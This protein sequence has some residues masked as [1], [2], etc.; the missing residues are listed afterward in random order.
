MTTVTEVT[1]RTEDATVAE[2]KTPVGDPF[3][4]P[5]PPVM[6][7]LAEDIHGALRDGFSAWP[8][9]GF[10]N[11]TQAG[12]AACITRDNGSAVYELFPAKFDDHMPYKPLVYVGRWPD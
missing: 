12:Y 2:W 10:V 4:T 5:L 8:G 6:L 11:V 1:I 3:Q 7:F 9:R